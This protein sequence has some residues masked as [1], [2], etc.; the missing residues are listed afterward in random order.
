MS[1]LDRFFLDKY[2]RGVLS[3][4]DIDKGFF[5]DVSGKQL[6]VKPYKEGDGIEVAS[7]FVR[8]L[9]SFDDPV[10]KRRLSKIKSRSFEV[11]YRDDRIR[12]IFHIES[13]IEEERLRAA[14]DSCYP[15][16]KIE[17]VDEV[18]PLN[19][20][21]PI[22]GG[23]FGL[24]RFNPYPI[25]H[26]GITEGRFNPFKKLSST[27][28]NIPGEA[29]IQILYVKSSKNWDKG[30][31]KDS[32]EEIVEGLKS[33]ELKT[34]A[35]GLIIQGKREAFEEEEKDAKRIIEKSR[36]KV[37]R[38]KIRYFVSGRNPRKIAD[39]LSK[40]IEYIY[41]KER[42]NS[43]KSVN[44]NQKEINS[45]LKDAIS[46]KWKP[47]RTVLSAKE[48]SG[49]SYIPNKYTDSKNINWTQNL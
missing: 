10:T 36:D 38:T 2:R 45:K 24:N 47:D 42:L 23:W 46:R 12:L 3:R 16:C 28:R 49:L 32:T 4:E 37:F 19:I 20:D 9:G 8:E 44:F 43:L 18:F 35:G 33:G 34:K 25:R 29:W 6:E 41:D 11:W 13:R 26:P 14:I 48:L 15:R 21:R 40:K 17:E 31:F 27:L 22:V 7:E 39:T 30:W 1:F 5:E